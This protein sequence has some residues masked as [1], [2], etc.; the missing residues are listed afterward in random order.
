MSGPS[1]RMILMTTTMGM[2]IIE[3]KAKV[4]PTP[5]AQSGYWYILL[6]VN[7]L[8]LTKEKIKQPWI[9]RGAEVYVFL[10][11]FLIILYLVIW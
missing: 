2:Q 10:N 3:A 5:M 8:Y 1:D 4:H 11:V 6:Y 9:G 7:G